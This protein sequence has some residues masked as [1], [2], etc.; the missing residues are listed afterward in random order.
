MVVSPPASTVLR[1]QPHP[2]LST[3]RSF[4]IFFGRD[5][6][7]KYL[8]YEI[9][10]NRNGAQDIESS[11]RNEEILDLVGLVVVGLPG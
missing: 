5:G 1:G 7:R 9:S 3:Y 2:I 11:G 6:L 4:I 10:E 8:E